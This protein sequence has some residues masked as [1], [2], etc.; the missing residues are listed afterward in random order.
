MPILRSRK[1]S[2][3]NESVCNFPSCELK[4]SDA[5]FLGCYLCSSSYHRECLKMDIDF[6]QALVSN[7]YHGTQWLCESCCGKRSLGTLGLNGLLDEM[8]KSLKEELSKEIKNELG[9][10]NKLFQ[11]HISSIE[12]KENGI[13]DLVSNKLQANSEVQPTKPAQV[14][15]FSILVKAG[16][17]NEGETSNGNG[18]VEG[19]TFTDETWSTVVKKSIKPKLK[20]IP[21]TKITRTKDGKGVLFSPQPNPV[22]RQ[23]PT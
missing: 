5:E 19:T 8:K 17:C 14:K 12:N 15:K 7:K 13:K 6:Y 18:D 4:S 11:A 10:F 3:E 16:N 23:P 20:T 9:S 21:V 1:G 22:I 2:L